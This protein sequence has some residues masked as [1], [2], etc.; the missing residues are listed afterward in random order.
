MPPKAQQPGDALV[1]IHCSNLEELEAKV[2]ALGLL[3]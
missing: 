2:L 1:D 3:E